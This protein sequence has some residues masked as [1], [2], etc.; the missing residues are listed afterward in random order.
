M[1]VGVR[2][3]VRVRCAFMACGRAV[4]AGQLASEWVLQLT[5]WLVSMFRCIRVCSSV[6]MRVRKCDSNDE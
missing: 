4:H 1:C 2:W 5:E 6:R 3:K